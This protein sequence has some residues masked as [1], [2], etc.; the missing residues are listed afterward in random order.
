MRTPMY[1]RLGPL[2][3]IDWGYGASIE[4][5]QSGRGYWVQGEDYTLLFKRLLECRTPE[6][7]IALL[8]SLMP[9]Q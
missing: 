2:E 8:M 5:T 6:E 7:Q 4:D 3:I 1:V 9:S